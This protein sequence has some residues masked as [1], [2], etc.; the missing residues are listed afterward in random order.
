L[1]L[2]AL[3]L[4]AGLFVLGYFWGNRYKQPEPPEVQSAIL[5]RP[6]LH[7]P[8]FQAL[9]YQGTELDLAALE[10]RWTL[11]LAGRLDDPGTARGLV[12]LTRVYNRL[13]AHPGIQRELRILLLSPEPE[14]DTAE[15]LQDT[16]FSYNP[17][18]NAAAGEP[19]ALAGLFAALGVADSANDVPTLYLLDTQVQALA[20][21]NGSDD[22]ASIASDLRSIQEATT[23]R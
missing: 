4:A 18:M 1:R 19:A 7:L 6:A 15:R 3:S 13:A 22:P 16:V 14:M 23:R 5:L 11:L 2:A 9:D 21:F 20:V 12:H 10:G 8:D 17:E